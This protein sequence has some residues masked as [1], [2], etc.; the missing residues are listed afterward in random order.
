MHMKPVNEK[1]SRYFFRGQSAVELAFVLPVFFLMIFGI[2]EG[3]RLI[4]T[5][6]ELTNATREGARYAVAHG[7]Q[8]SSTAASSDVRARVLDKSV[9]L[10][11]A[12]LTVSTSWPDG[13]KEA[14]SRVR[15]AA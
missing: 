14:G 10:E 6:N 1:R 15:V 9:G 3:A 8:A 5:Y 4:F 13:Y 11:S 12:A 7:T 2:I